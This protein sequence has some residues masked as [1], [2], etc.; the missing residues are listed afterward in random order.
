MKEQINIPLDIPNVRVIKTGVNNQGDYIVTVESLEEDTI[1]RECGRQIKHFHSYDRLISIRH[2]PILGRGVYIRMRPKRYECKYCNQ[3]GKRTTTTQ[4]LDW[5]DPKSR[6]TKAYE[7]H[8]LKQLINST[9]EDVSRKENFGYDAIEG[10]IA[11]RID[12][13]VDWLGIDHLSVLGIDEIS[14]KKGHRQYVVIVSSRLADGT[15]QLLAILPNREKATV[16]AFLHRI[17]KRLKRTIHTVCTDMWKAYLFAAQEELAHAKI[18][19]DRFHVAQKYHDCADQL[20]KQEIKRLKAEL[21]KDEQET[22][23]HTMWPFRKHPDDLEDDETQRLQR[24]FSLSPDLKLAYQFRLDLTHIFEKNLDKDQA[25]LALRSWATQ[26]RDS[27]LACFDT[28]LKTLDTYFEFITNYFLNRHSSG[29]V[30]GLNHKIK[31]LKQRCY[32]L[33]NFKHLFQRLF[34]D[35]NGYSLFP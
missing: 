31:V 27:S 24:L 23:K 6:Q 22:L 14:L 20:R 35:L 21:S 29:F 25:A 8:I 13:Q 26:V 15:V 32:G 9:I 34:L 16:K 33:R 11:R 3:K 17:P 30:E 4:K 10:I 7:D 19:V 2:L 1:C 18:V 28:F 12:D 5:Y